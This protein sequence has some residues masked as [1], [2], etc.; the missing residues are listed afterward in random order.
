MKGRD[1]LVDESR[2]AVAKGLV[3]C[4]E[5]GA[6]DHGVTVRVIFAK[7]SLGK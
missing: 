3:V 5:Q 4:M 2:K 7:R 1:L 6:F